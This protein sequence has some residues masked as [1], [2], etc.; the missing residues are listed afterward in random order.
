MFRAR[1]RAV[2]RADGNVQQGSTGP[3]TM[4]TVRARRL[5]GERPR[6]PALRA[7]GTELR[8]GKAATVHVRWGI[9]PRAPVQGV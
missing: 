2:E 6:D 8:L 4:L 9:A 1:Q 5:A 3:C 7:P